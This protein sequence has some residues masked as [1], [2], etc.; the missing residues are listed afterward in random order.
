MNTITFTYLNIFD[1]Q[2]GD[3]FMFKPLKFGIFLHFFLIASFCFDYIRFLHIVSCSTTLSTK[4]TSLKRFAWFSL[5]F[6]GSPPLSALNNSRSN[7]IFKLLDTEIA[8]KVCRCQTFNV[9]YDIYIEQAQQEVNYI[10]RYLSKHYLSLE[11]RFGQIY[12]A[13]ITKFRSDF[14]KQLLFVVSIFIYFYKLAFYLVIFFQTT[15]LVHCSMFSPYFES[16]TY[17]LTIQPGLEESCDFVMTFFK[18]IALRVSFKLQ[19]RVFQSL[20]VF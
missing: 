4:V 6:A 5:I 7:T 17:F 12:L 19:S 13:F 11:A 2:I 8:K 3:I 20:F 9:E 16:L 15:S 10:Y 18:A 14:F 1:N